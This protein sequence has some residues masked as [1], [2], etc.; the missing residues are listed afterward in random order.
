MAVSVLHSKVPKFLFL[1]VWQTAQSF[2]SKLHYVNAEGTSKSYATFPGKFL[3]RNIKQWR[4]P[5]WSV[6]THVMLPPPDSTSTAIYIHSLGPLKANIYSLLKTLQWHHF[7][8][9]HC[10]KNLKSAPS[11]E[12]FQRGLNIF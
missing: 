3:W 8:G 6:V 2:L 4:V 11:V 12:R 9:T 5:Q 1:I 7:Y 10:Q